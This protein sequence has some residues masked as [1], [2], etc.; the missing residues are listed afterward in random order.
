MV[1]KKGARNDGMLFEI[2]S[3]TLSKDHIT[4]IERLSKP[5]Q[6]EELAEELNLKATIIRTLLNDLHAKS[7]VEYDRTK[8]KRT[9]WYTY[10]WKVREDK[11]KEYVQSYL[12]NKLD[13][14]SSG[15]DQ[16]TGMVIFN[17]SC[18]RVPFDV[19]FENNFFCSKCNKKFEE[20]NN[21]KMVTHLKT[22]IAR[23]NSLLEER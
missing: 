11:L 2:L 19:A 13:Q 20:F 4:I 7:L 5:K 6:D 8:N 22:E 15:I 3:E 9:G 12:E 14:L 16:E 23:I 21:K 1:K 18:S 17:C 10:I